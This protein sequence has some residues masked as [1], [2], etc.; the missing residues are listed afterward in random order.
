MRVVSSLAVAATI[1]S[2]C[3]PTSVA[4]VPPVWTI[5]VPPVGLA[6]ATQRTVAVTTG[7]PAPTE[8]PPFIVRIERTER[9]KAVAG[10][11]I[12]PM[13]LSSLVLVE[14]RVTPS[15]SLAMRI[16]QDDEHVTGI[17]PI[18]SLLGKGYLV[19]TAPKGLEVRAAQGDDV[20]AE[21]RARVSAMART[22]MG[23]P[24]ASVVGG[25]LT[26][27]EETTALER[28]VAAIV[29]TPLHGTPAHEPRVLVRFKGPEGESDR[30][31]DVFAVTVT[32][33]E[34]DAGMCHRWAKEADLR[35]ELRVR[36]HGGALL[37]LHLEGTTSETEALCQGP[38]GT[39]PPLPPRTCNRG[40]IL[41][42]IKQPDAP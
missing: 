34:Q 11:Q 7:S 4:T 36:A 20:V 6:L 25:P 3:A 33:S 16:V 1:L 35:G 24:G 2:G 15:G 42:D 5:P 19:D 30:A 13:S 9:T 17:P 40:T 32:A 28:P 8:R 10:C 37:A 18:G 23:W 31:M 26:P 41:I 14:D 29:Q 12:T 21:T 27:G 38:S 39:G 22:V